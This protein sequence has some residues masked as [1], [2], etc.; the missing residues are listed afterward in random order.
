MVGNRLRLRPWAGRDGHI[1]I[2][3][4][5]DGLRRSDESK[6]R[7]H[8]AKRF[9]PWE[10]TGHEDKQPA[11]WIT[12]RR[13]AGA[14]PPCSEALVLEPRGFRRAVAARP[15]RRRLLR[16]V[17]VGLAGIAVGVGP[18][19]PRTG[20]EE[21]PTAASVQRLDLPAGGVAPAAP[22][23][24]RPRRPPVRARSAGRPCSASSRPG[25]PAT[26]SP[27]ACSTRPA[28][29]ATRR[30]P[31]SP[32]PRPTG[33]W[34][35][36]PC[37]SGASAGRRDQQPTRHRHPV[38]PGGH[39]PVRRA[40]P[41]A[42][43][44]GVAGQPPGRPL[45]GRRRPGVGP[46]RP[47]RDDRAPEAVT[48]WVERLLG[49]DRQGRPASRPGRA[50]RAGRPGRA[51]LPGARPLDGGRPEGFDAAVEPEAYVAAFGPEVGSWA[52]LVPVQGHAPASR[53][54]RPAGRRLARA[55]RHRPRQ[56]PMRGGPRPFVPVLSHP[57]SRGGI[58]CPSSASS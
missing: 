31:A 46:G 7:R 10:R 36:P 37:G 15:D 26:P 58:S 3:G 51:A 50:V 30:W 44:R 42:H 19:W 9:R 54:R 40:G 32:A 18:P 45:A 27:T 43:G 14:R 52:R 20:S 11:G 28:A 22:T 39:R 57:S 12:A 25:R 29:S 2:L 13:M 8:R 55:A 34:S 5:G 53:G 16:V 56:G 17:G 23:P 47:A 48:A 24:R 4:A 49:C 1:P 33:P 6:L 21:A 41:G 35:R 38:P